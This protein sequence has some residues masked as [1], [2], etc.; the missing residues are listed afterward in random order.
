MEEEMIH[1]IHHQGYNAMSERFWTCSVGMYKFAQRQKKKNEKSD[2]DIDS[3]GVSS[4]RT[5]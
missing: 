3:D 2:Y 5:L 1:E 4:E